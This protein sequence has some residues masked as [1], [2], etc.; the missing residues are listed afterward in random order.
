MKNIISFG[1]LILLFVGCTSQ[2]DEPVFKENNS[3][4]IET[5]LVKSENENQ[6][7]IEITDSV[8]SMTYYER[9]EYRFQNGEYERAI[10]DFIVA[11]SINRNIHAYMSLIGFTENL[12]NLIVEKLTNKF[13]KHPDE[14]KWPYYI[15]KVYYHKSYYEEALLAFEKAY[16]IENKPVY[17]ILM[18]DCLLKLKE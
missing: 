8:I 3:E 6:N 11:L 18:E 13:N 2:S 14:A 17:K 9:G 1:F 4:I 10:D 7:Y 15:G 5:N 12:T 16:N